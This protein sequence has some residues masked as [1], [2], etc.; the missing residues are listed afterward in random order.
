M[1]NLKETF[2]KKYGV[3]E[4]VLF[5]VGLAI[6]SRVVYSIIIADFK[7]MTWTEI[8][9]ITL[10]LCLGVLAVAKPLA[11]IEYAKKKAGI[12][13]SENKQNERIND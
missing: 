9:I 6:L 11:I 2:L 3:P 12:E 5:L 10:F 4:Y 7:D 13:T 8:G 1:K